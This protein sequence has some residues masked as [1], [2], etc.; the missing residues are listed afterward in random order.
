MWVRKIKD[1]APVTPVVAIAP[2]R[3]LT[4]ADL[5]SSEFAP[6]VMTEDPIFDSG[7]FRNLIANRFAQNF[8]DYVHAADQV[9]TLSTASGPV[10]CYEDFSYLNHQAEEGVIAL[11][12]PDTPT[13]LSM[14]IFVMDLGW[15]FE[16]PAC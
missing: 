14:G 9:I 6:C 7:A 2:S 13:V 8:P 5:K 15:H 4:E 1:E 12:L 11:V 3:H 10:E 16:W